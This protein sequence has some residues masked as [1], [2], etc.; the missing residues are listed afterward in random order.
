MTEFSPYQLAGLFNRRYPGFHKRQA[1]LRFFEDCYKGGRDWFASNIFR[2]YKEGSD[3]YTARVARAYRFNHTREVV[4]LVHK[5]LFKGGIARNIDAAPEEVKKFW[6]SATRNG[7]NIDQL[8]RG[9]AVEASIGGRVA[10]VVD[11][12]APSNADA[13]SVRDMKAN[14]IGVYAYVVPTKDILDLAFDEDD[15]GKLSWI[16]LREYARDD[17]DPFT[18]TGDIV[19]R[20]RL[21]TR[22]AWFLFEEEIEPA[23]TETKKVDFNKSKPSEFIPSSSP[24]RAA[25][26]TASNNSERKVKLISSALHGLDRVPV[27]LAD[28]T[29]TDSPYIVPGLIEDISYLDRAIANYLSS[30]DA[31]IQDQTFS[32]LIIPHQAIASDE[33]AYSRI[34]EMGTKRVVVYDGGTGSTAKP[35]YIAP[36]PKQAGVILN[37]V[38]KL[39][40]EI[41]HTVGLAGER[42]KED[43]AVGIDNSSGVAKA[44]DFERVNSL[45]LSKAHSC[46][47]VENEIV[48]I[49]MAWHNQKEPE[50]NLVTYPT[51]F[52]VM[53]LADD[54][55]TAEALMRINAPDEVRREHMRMFTDKLFPQLDGETRSAIEKGIKEW[56]EQLVLTAPPTSF[57]GSNKAAAAP[58]RQGSVTANTDQT[59]KKQ[60]K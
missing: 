36:D 38:N 54:L 53:R 42:T 20:V 12:N 55:V 23:A 56:P 13:I 15:N 24:D 50:D 51:T 26:L 59:S 10:V 8:M 1:E 6:K 58:K 29:I 47:L 39:I 22:D 45:L 43:N 9:A 18:S 28:H 32:Q 11:N 31:I 2:Y 17:S 41:Y 35:E 7:L 27:V 37:V 19:Q 60:V 34:A 33:D 14:N 40:N 3:E 52:D 16:M 25:H 5:Y 44:Y 21:W 46:E 30:L 48:S 49:V 4:E 57:G